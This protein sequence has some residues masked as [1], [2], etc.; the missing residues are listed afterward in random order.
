MFKSASDA[1]E[2]VKEVQ[3]ALE[4]LYGSIN[5]PK[6]YINC[7][8]SGDDKNNDALCQGQYLFAAKVFARESI[9]T[10]APPPSPLALKFVKYDRVGN[11]I[12]WQRNVGEL[13]AS[14]QPTAAS[15]KN[16]ASP[17][18]TAAFRFNQTPAHK[19][20]QGVPVA[21]DDYCVESPHPRLQ[22]AVL[23]QSLH[24]LRHTQALAHIATRFQTNANY[25]FAKLV[26]STLARTTKHVCH[27]TT[28]HAGNFWKREQEELVAASAV[29][30]SHGTR[31]LE[32]LLHLPRLFALE[33]WL[34]STDTEAMFGCVTRSGISLRKHYNA[35]F[36]WIALRNLFAAY[37]F[38]HDECRLVHHD[39]S[40]SNVSFQHG[41]GDKGDAESLR[42]CVNDF[43]FSRR[44]PANKAQRSLCTM[45]SGSP[46]FSS[47]QKW[48]VAPH[49]DE[50]DECFALGV[51]AY[52]ILYGTV[53][54]PKNVQNVVQMK[55]LVCAQLRN[56]T[57]R[58][59]WRDVIDAPDSFNAAIQQCVAK[60]LSFEEKERPPMRALVETLEKIEWN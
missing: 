33:T 31:Q 15:E 19:L 26:A 21:G 3:D 40:L 8:N 13:A 57:F 58:V 60:L 36:Y 1:Q 7:A 6:T 44:L 50:S 14:Q 53:C 52:F 9:D 41:G 56:G 54:W 48:V 22:K 5:W 27:C 11:L 17:H 24:L 39:V 47:P 32:S 55:Q 42:V 45:H 49:D 59:A 46:M 25:R 23:G 35:H 38:L 10:T 43:G 12:D 29:A 4:M 37:R 30:L 2:Y 34:V 16:F 51:L 28:K 20:F 18:E